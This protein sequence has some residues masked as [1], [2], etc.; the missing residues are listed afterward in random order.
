MVTDRVLNAFLNIQSNYRNMK[1]SAFLQYS[2][3]CECLWGGGAG[4]GYISC[5]FQRG[6]CTY[7]LLGG[8]GG[9]IQNLDNGLE[10]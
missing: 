10:F 9:V 8:G 1:T 3:K 4:S 2:V 5:G 7:I 6:H